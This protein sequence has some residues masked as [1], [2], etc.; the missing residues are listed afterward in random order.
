[1][2]LHILNK[3]VVSIK[4]TRYLNG[5]AEHGWSLN[6]SR[7][8]LGVLKLFINHFGKRVQSLAAGYC[9]A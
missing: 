8:N 7:I 5:Y 1:M 9:F 4:I 2:K 3:N 6:E